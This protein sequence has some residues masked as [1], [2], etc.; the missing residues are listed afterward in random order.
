MTRGFLTICLADDFGRLHE[1]TLLTQK[2]H[3]GCKEAKQSYGGQKSGRSDDLKVL[4]KEISRLKTKIKKL[5]SECE[6]EENELKAAEG[7]I[8]MNH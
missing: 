4:G 3:G 8:V 2:N 5:E 6:T 7:N 1:R